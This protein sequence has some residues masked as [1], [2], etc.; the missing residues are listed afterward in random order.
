MNF[1]PLLQRPVYRA[2]AD[3]ARYFH[4]H[5][6]GDALPKRSDFR[7]TAVRALLGY[8]FLIDVIDG[9]ADYRFA[10]TGEHMVALYGA[11][12][13]HL[14]LSE[15]GDDALRASLKQ[16]YD[17]VVATRA[18]HY[19]RG[20]YVW[21]DKSVEIERLLVPMGGADGTVTTILGIVVPARPTEHAH[22][23]SGIGAGTLQIDEAVVGVE[24]VPA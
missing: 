23:F 1:E 6:P 10:L 2:I 19:V 11:D 15:F 18:F 3:I 14:R 20:C 24:A 4:D 21:A 16:T 13:A 7:P 12:I 5:A 17:A 9:G 22:L 8:Y